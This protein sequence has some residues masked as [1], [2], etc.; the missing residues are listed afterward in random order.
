MPGINFFDLNATN[1][2]IRAE[3]DAAYQRVSGSGWFILGPEVEAFEAE[4]AA[5]CDAKHCVGVANGLDALTL[6]LRARGVG[7]GDEVI[8]PSHTFIATWLAAAATGATI[9]PVEV[10]ETTYTLSADAVQAAITPRTA[11]VIPVSLYGHPVEIDPLMKLAERHGF[12]VIEDAAQSHGARYLGRRTGS[13]AHAT[14]FSFYPTKNLGALGDAGGV[15]TNDSDLSEK[16]RL[17]RN[18]G[19]Q[20]KYVHIAIGGNSRLDEMQAAFLRAKLPHLD[21]W[22]S[23]R[24][25]VAS[26]FAQHLSG[27]PGVIAPQTANWAEHVFHLYVVR[28]GQRDRIAEK[29]KQQGVSTLI[30]YPIACHLQEAFAHLG[31]R[32]GAFPIAERLADEVLSLPMW[33]QM[34]TGVPEVVAKHLAEAASNLGLS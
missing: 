14:A 29:L 27:I 23:Q 32:Q 24:R 16:V 25:A 11:A 10:D 30:H 18:Y 6:I 19:S 21:R 17:L 9:V 3:L 28:V 22:N 33:P 2:E 20:K 8:V 12:I 34:D 5:Y 1:G 15:V 4:F 31:Y 26:A 13:L 7:P